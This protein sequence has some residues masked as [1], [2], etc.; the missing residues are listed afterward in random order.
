M[1]TVTGD[2]TMRESVER[3]LDWN[4]QLDASHVAVS[5]NDGAIVLTGHVPTYAEKWETKEATER[6]YGVRAVVDE[7][8]VKL[9]HLSTRDDG[10]I[11]EDTARHLRT[12]TA[13]PV[14]VRAEVKNGHVTLEGEVSWYYQRT[15]A[16]RALRYLRGV[17]GL[18]NLITVSPHQVKTADVTQ[19]ISEA[20]ER[21]AHLDARSVWATSTNGAVR[22]HGHVHSFSEKQTAGLAAA[23]AP[24]VTKVENDVVVSP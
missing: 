7:L 4:A 24:G 11:A 14:G 3:E 10:D 19:R 12:S 23:S 8:E 22:L 16:E 17:T 9:A 5:A 15:E 18:T 13:I 21:M 6:V 20:I 1:K 2:K